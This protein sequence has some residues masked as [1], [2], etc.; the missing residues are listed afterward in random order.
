MALDHHR[1]GQEV[2][3]CGP[4]LMVAGSRLRLLAAGVPA[5]RIHLPTEHVASP[6]RFFRFGGYRGD[7]ID[8][9]GGSCDGG[10]RRRI[11]AQR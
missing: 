2:Y 11:G 5:E 1:P 9:V 8:D 6:Y 3:L 10:T 4:P 7:G